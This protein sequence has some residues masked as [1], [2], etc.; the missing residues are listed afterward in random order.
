MLKYGISDKGCGKLHPANECG[1]CAEKKP[2]CKRR[3]R[4]KAKKQINTELEDLR[5]N[6]MTKNKGFG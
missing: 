5:T 2:P 1:A 4:N 3:A 6:Q